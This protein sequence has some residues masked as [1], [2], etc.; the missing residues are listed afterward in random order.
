MSSLTN[1]KPSSATAVI[2][3][4]GIVGNSLAYHL[5]RLGWRHLVLVDKGPMPRPGGSTGHASNF[6]FPIDYSKMMAELTLDSAEQYRALG[7]FIECGGIELA[8]T[9]ARLDEQRRRASAGRA[10]Q[11]PCA[12]LS[13]SEV[14]D[15]VPYVD[16][17]VIS[18]GLYM[19]TTGVVD[20]VRAGTLMREQAV[21]LGALDVRAG[22]EV[23]GIDVA[24]GRV[25]AVLTTSGE[26]ETDVCAICCGV[27]S[28]RLARMAGAR[29]PLTPIVHQMTRVGRTSRCSRSWAPRSVSRSCATST[30]TCTSASTARTWKSGPMPIA[31]SPS[32]RT[33]YPP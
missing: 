24:G 13:P 7:V 10:W 22:T 1:G 20:S 3:G 30:T 4:A 29:I 19:P 17:S 28:P 14:R 18:G 33:R 9:T 11:I 5:A 6:I 31:P 32:S 27:W 25:R 8:R 16:A 21:E 26:I 2:V 15:L 23:L 12:R